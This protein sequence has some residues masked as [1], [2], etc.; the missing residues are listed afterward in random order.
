MIFSFIQSPPVNGP[1][2]RGAKIRFSYPYG[3]KRPLIMEPG[4]RRDDFDITF[5]SDSISYT[6]SSGILRVFPCITAGIPEELP[7]N[8]QRTREEPAK[9]TGSN[10]EGI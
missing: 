5:T 7:K 9:N 8:S 2:I 4:T 3:I 1:Y 6:G 10:M